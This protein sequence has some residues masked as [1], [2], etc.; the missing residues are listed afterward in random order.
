MEKILNNA[1]YIKTYLIN[2]KLILIFIFYK[3]FLVKYYINK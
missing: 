1:K 2:D 3:D